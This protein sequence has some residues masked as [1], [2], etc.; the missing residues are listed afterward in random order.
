MI[1]WSLVL[2]KESWSGEHY[3][4]NHSPQKKWNDDLFNRIKLKK[5]DSVLDIGCGDGTHAYR[6]F[7]QNHDAE[8]IGIDSSKSMIE[9]AKKHHKGPKFQHR[10]YTEITE[11]KEFDVITSFSM[12]H[13]VEDKDAFLNFVFKALKPGGLLYL[14]F[15]VEGSANR[16]G[17][18]LL[19]VANRWGGDIQKMGLGC[20]LV[21]ADD[22]KNMLSNAGFKV[23]HFDVTQKKQV[24]PNRQTMFDWIYGFLPHKKF[25]QK[26]KLPVLLMT[27]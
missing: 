22:F 2:A 19:C 26:K 9:T 21:K 10:S 11:E 27:L 4:K 24:F 25:C 17:N 3:H 5:Y 20:H 7:K 12:L 16:I 6:L 13:F 23:E 14:A 15:P 8:I 18:A 1:L